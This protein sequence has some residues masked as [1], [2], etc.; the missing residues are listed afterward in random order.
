MEAT[1]VLQQYSSMCIR[2][3]S[4]SRLICRE[5][6]K[7]STATSFATSCRGSQLTEAAV[8]TRSEA[9]RTFQRVLGW[10]GGGELRFGK[11]EDVLSPESS[12]KYEQLLFTSSGT[13]SIYSTY[14][15]Y[16]SSPPDFRRVHTRYSKDNMIYDG[17]AID[18]STAVLKNV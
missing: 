12:R 14:E 17:E 15:V 16:V 2:S 18:Q 5:G 1:T 6:H 10:P 7:S 8:R 9:D 11:P 4:P 13:T 3:S